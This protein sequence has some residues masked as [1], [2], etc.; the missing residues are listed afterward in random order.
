MLLIVYDA[1]CEVPFVGG[2]G[3]MSLLWVDDTIPTQTSISNADREA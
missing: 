3:A 2:G 1:L